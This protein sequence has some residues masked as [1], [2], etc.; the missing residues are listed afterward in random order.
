MGIQRVFYLNSI[1]VLGVDPAF[2]V[3]LYSYVFA[4]GNKKGCFAF[5]QGIGGCG[6]CLYT[7]LSF[8]R[9]VFFTDLSHMNSEY[10]GII[11]MM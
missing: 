3:R 6:A 10:F 7:I 5:A 9:T 11:L 1:G 4:G 8:V 2:F